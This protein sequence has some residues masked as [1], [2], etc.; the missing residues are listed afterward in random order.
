MTTN[1]TVNSSPAVGESVDAT[2]GASAPAVEVLRI[3]KAFPGVVAN[4]DISLSLYKGE[5]HCL[6]GENGAGKSTLMNILSGMYQPDEGTIKVGGRTVVIDTPKAAIDLGIGMVYQHSTMIPV[7]TVLENLMLGATERVRLDRKA[8]ETALADLSGKLAVEIE[9]GAVTGKL[10]LGQQQQVEIIKALWSGSSVLI[11]DEPT[12]MLTPQGIADLQ[13]V[14]VQLKQHGLAIVFIT[15]KLYEAIEIGDR[16]SVLKQGCV[17]G[18][19]EPEDLHSKSADELQATIV[20]MMFGEEA[21]SLSEVAEIKQMSRLQREKRDLSSTLVLEVNNVSVKAGRGEVDV[22]EVSLQVRR[23][24]IMGI[25]GVDGNGQRE[26]AEALAGQ[27]KLSRGDI[28]LTGHQVGR[29]SVAERQKLGLRFVTDDRLGEGMVATLPVSLNLF[30]KRIGERPFWKGGRIQEEMICD[31]A[32]SLVRAFDIRTPTVETHCGA[33]SGGN[34][35]KMV[36]ARE[37]SF[38]PKVVVY[39]KPTYGLDVKTTRT[40]RDRI[41]EL[42]DKKG[43]SAVLISTDLEELLD[44]CDRI[45]VMF[46]GRLTG[47]VENH[48]AGVE[49]QVGKLM[50]GGKGDSM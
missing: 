5:V 12:S 25:A 4:K 36:L 17:V 45:G 50:L 40:I 1:N 48:G 49:A 7:F 11:L 23:G 24:E 31:S 2:A 13:E 42:S 44:L 22:H 39:N 38:E 43:V 28:V 32:E 14:L 19:L 20:G 8:A 37:L 33:L 16:V 47:V 10:A 27:R 3:T 34:I 29:A 15:H 35:Q 26:L 21:R 46:R 41:R 30:L 9:P 6:L 18:R